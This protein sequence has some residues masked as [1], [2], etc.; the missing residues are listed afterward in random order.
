MSIVTKSNKTGREVETAKPEALKATSLDEVVERLGEE[1]TL[2]KV[3]A[4]LTIDF[5]SHVR[6][7]LEAGD[8]ENEDY[9]HELDDVASMDFSEW[10][11]QTQTRKSAEEKAADLLGKLTPEQIQAALAMAG[12]NS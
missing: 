6:S 11:P 10:V 12:K 3:L 7:L 9:T 2:K 8:I 5:R 4:Q 1:M